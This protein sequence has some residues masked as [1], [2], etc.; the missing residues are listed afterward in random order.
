MLALPAASVT[1]QMMPNLYGP[2]ISLDTA[3]KVAAPALAEATKNNWTMALAIVDP[4]GI[5]VYYEK[6]DNTPCGVNATV[7]A[8]P[9]WL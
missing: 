2:P 3:K 4:A 8:R 7:R 1:A 6:Q 5:L 9:P